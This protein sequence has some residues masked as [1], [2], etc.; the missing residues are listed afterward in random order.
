MVLDSAG[1]LAVTNDG[2]RWRRKFRQAV[3]WKFCP[4]EARNAYYRSR[5][6]ETY[7]KEPYSGA[8]VHLKVEGESTP[9]PD[10][11]AGTF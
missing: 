8:L 1:S 6:N 3:K 5:E 9:A 4:N 7:Q 11:Y 10:F 2:K